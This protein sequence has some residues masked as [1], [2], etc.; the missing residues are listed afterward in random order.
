MAEMVID[1]LEVI[2]V[3]H[4]HGHRVPVS[5]GSGFLRGQYLLKMP[6]VMKAGKPIGD[7]QLLQFLILSPQLRQ[8]TSILLNKPLVLESLLHGGRQL[9]EVK[10]LGEVTEG[11][12]I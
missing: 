1:V 10:R 4:H 11:T 12:L 5:L 9:S 3:N 8:Q 7:G 6:A 2:D